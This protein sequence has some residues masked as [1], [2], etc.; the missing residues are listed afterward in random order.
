[1]P[2]AEEETEEVDEEEQVVEVGESDPLSST[3][4][5]TA[6]RTPPAAGMSSGDTASSAALPWPAPGAE[7]AGAA[8]GRAYLWK[9]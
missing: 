7:V 8:K 6:N 5:E 9:R 1:L 4:S 3:E 2:A